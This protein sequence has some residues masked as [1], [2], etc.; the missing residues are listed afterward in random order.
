[1]NA[2]SEP[3]NSLLGSLTESTQRHIHPIK[4]W[5]KELQ[6]QLLAKVHLTA[7]INS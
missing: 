1:M 5:G 7:T 6:Q 2:S 4:D 3:R